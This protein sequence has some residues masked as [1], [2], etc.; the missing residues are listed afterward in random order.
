MCV[1]DYYINVSLNF[2]NLHWEHKTTSIVKCNSNSLWIF[3]NVTYFLNILLYAYFVAFTDV[4]ISSTLFAVISMKILLDSTKLENNT[5][6]R[7]IVVL[8]I[9]ERK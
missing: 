3:I 6:T 9:I 4:W 5:A 1:C 2:N 8:V 7:F